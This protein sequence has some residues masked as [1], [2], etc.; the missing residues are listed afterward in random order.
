MLKKKKYTYY[1]D[2]SNPFLQ[3]QL[4]TWSFTG[5]L[6]NYLRSLLK[7]ENIWKSVEY[8]LIFVGIST[9]LMMSFFFGQEEKYFLGLLSAF[10][11]KDFPF[12]VSFS[13]LIA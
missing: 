11:G 12:S 6:C 4:W 1:R 10:F 3:A 2:Y 5:E 9:S 8:S 13:V 7:M